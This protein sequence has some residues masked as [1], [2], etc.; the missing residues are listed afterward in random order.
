MLCV[1]VRDIDNSG[2]GCKGTNG[3]GAA[4]FVV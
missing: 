2:V 1:Q 3:F 4:T